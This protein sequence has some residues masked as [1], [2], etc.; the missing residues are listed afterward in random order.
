MKNYNGYPFTYEQWQTCI[1][2]LKS[3]KDDPFNNP[4]NQQL[5]AL[6]KK[7]YKKAKNTKRNEARSERRKEDIV[8]SKK[9]VIV[10]NALNKRTT[11]N[12]GT[13][14]T[15]R[16]Y[17]TLKN[18][19][20]C[21]SCNKSYFNMHFHYHKLC[22][23]CA[24][25]SYMYRF[26]DIDL[27]NRNVIITGGRVKIGYATTL[28]LLESG[29][30]VTITTRFPALALERF[31]WHTNYNQWKNRLF[32]YGLDLRNVS[33]INSFIEFYKQKHKTLDILINN[34]AQTIKYPDNYYQP[35]LK[36]EQRLIKDYYRNSEQLIMNKT[37]VIQSVNSLSSGTI[38][39]KI[40]KL[41][42]FG[43]PVDER[44]KTSWNSRLEEVSMLELIEVNL[45]N[46]IAPYTLIKEFLPLLKASEN[47]FKFIIN[48]TSTE[49]MFSHLNKTIYHP[50]T[51]MTKAA[52]NMLTR[53]SAKDFEKDNI[54]M[55]SVDVGWVSTG[56]IEPLRKRQFEEG[57]VPPL[58]PVDG[59]ARIFHPIIDTFKNN[60]ISFSGCLL[61]DFKIEN[62]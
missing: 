40:F 25:Q 37:P 56:A 39:D 58:D 47:Q 15:T 5:S 27:K 30:N 9:T 54:S 35:L 33:A 55:N 34:A 52:L 48:V 49:G 6:I 32:I 1:E 23:V 16:K 53:T 2:V 18:Q 19:R 13:H 61:K 4:D 60:N 24:E 51:N 17:T 46:Q 26:T 21:Y 7:I 44:L 10:K 31:R 57:Y 42:R 50:H 20:N 45:I 38:L 59:A 62:W 3:L 28:R 36:K 8:S 14:Q 41:N 29:A 43:Q 12:T 22:P 11:Y